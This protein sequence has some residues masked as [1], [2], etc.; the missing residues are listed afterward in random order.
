MTKYSFLAIPVLALAF[1]SA[2]FYAS[3]SFADQ[4]LE[5]RIDSDNNGVIDNSPFE[6]KL[7]KS[8]YAFGKFIPYSETESEFVEIQVAIPKAKSAGEKRSL[9]FTFE[10][11][12]V[13]LWEESPDGKKVCLFK[14][15]VNAPVQTKILPKHCNDN[16]AVTPAPNSADEYNDAAAENDNSLSGLGERLTGN[17]TLNIDVSSVRKFLDINIDNIIPDEPDTELVEIFQPQTFEYPKSVSAENAILKFYLKSEVKPRP[18]DWISS[19]MFKR[20][21][22]TLSVALKDV[23]QTSTDSARYMVV[24][25]NSI[26]DAVEQIPEL[27]EA[28]AARAVYFPGFNVGKYGLETLDLNKLGV[29]MEDFVCDSS[30]FRVRVYRDWVHDKYYVAFKG[31]NIRLSDFQNDVLLC[32]GK[33]SP[34]LWKALKLGHTLRSKLRPHGKGKFVLVGHS[35]GGA[36]ASGACITS[37]IPTD[38]FNALGLSYQTLKNTVEK[39]GSTDPSYGEIKAQIEKCF[40]NPQNPDRPDDREFITGTV[41][42]STFHTQSDLLTLI[43]QCNN[44]IRLQTKKG[45]LLY[46]PLALGKEL[47]IENK[48]QRP[49]IPAPANGSIESLRNV[50]QALYFIVEQCDKNNHDSIQMRIQKALGIGSNFLIDP[51]SFH[52]M[53]DQILYAMSS[54]VIDAVIEEMLIQAGCSETFEPRW[55]Q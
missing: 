19:K 16:A 45:S 2:P 26:Y 1:L 15:D 7:A 41:P 35:L 40:M 21:T 11:N 14:P 4:G 31:T 9:Q 18:A 54:H 8:P 22:R 39:Y 5:L 25:Q 27:S 32:I 53:K 49:A 38:T 20:P 34:Y 29:P 28:L 42:L 46:I 48:G 6:R 52:E 50:V 33:P 51:N 37:E 23:K 10:S 17:V 44:K 36:L 12:E 13:S 43:E 55:E 24:G 3:T 30:G 47:K